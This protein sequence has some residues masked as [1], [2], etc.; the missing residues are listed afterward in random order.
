MKTIVSPLLTLS[1][2]AFVLSSCI[3]DDVKISTSHYTAEEIQT[4]QKYLDLPETRDEYTVQIAEHML[5]SGAQA[6]FINDAK[7]T[8]G[9]VLFYD[10]KL[11]KTNET[12]CASCHKQSL[13]FSD[14]KALSDGI[15]GQKTKRNSLPLAS[16]ANFSSSYDG[17]GP[18]FSGGIGFFWDERASTISEQSSL[19]IQDDIEMGM[20]M[21]ELAVKLSQEEYYKILFRKAYGEEIISPNLILDAIQEFVNSFVSTQSPFDEGLNRM[22]SVDVFSDFSNFSAQ[23]N[24][25]KRLFVENCSS[26]HAADMSTATAINMANNGLDAVYED[27]GLGART[28]NEADNGVFKV[29]FL[30]NIELT[31]PYMHDGR[32]NT[33]EEVV[34]HYSTGIKAHPNLSDQLKDVYGNPRRFNFTAEEKAALVAFLKTVTDDNFVQQGRFADP[35]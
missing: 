22:N 15:N 25:G 26:C 21:D 33:L 4:L 16:V 20:D 3:A 24:M 18:S 29:P 30:R 6:P 19:T 5:K 12:S 35:F 8:L 27:N 7:A 10:T 28:F 34:E 17:G 14:D 9:R 13:A 23:E 32:F 31:Y 1:I 2:L 11:S